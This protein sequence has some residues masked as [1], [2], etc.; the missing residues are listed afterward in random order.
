MEDSERSG[1]EMGGAR[2]D[3]TPLPILMG[4]VMGMVGE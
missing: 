3:S 4:T 2:R 1:P